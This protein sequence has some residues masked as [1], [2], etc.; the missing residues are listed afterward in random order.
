MPAPQGDNKLSLVPSLEGGKEQLKTL[1]DKLFPPERKEMLN[2]NT[3][4]ILLYKDH[5]TRKF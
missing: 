2:L 5:K 4:S 3:L 1:A